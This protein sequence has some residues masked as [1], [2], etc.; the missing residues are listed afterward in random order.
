[1]ESLASR[2]PPRRSPTLTASVGSP[3]ACLI[4]GEDVVRRAPAAS[5]PL[6]P[7]SRRKQR[8]RHKHSLLWPEPQ[9]PAVVSQ[10]DFCFTPSEPGDIKTVYLEKANSG[11]THT[12][13]DCRANISKSA[14]DNSFLDSKPSCELI[15]NVFTDNQVENVLC[16]TESAFL[17]TKS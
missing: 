9:R 15:D 1:M 12:L 10:R 14:I 2:S 17:E 8:P 11:T 6:A 5:A 7:T 16:V 4:F 3:V 13:H